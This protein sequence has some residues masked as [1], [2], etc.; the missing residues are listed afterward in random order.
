MPSD[1]NQKSVSVPALKFYSSPFVIF[2]LAIVIIFVAEFLVM[3][4][5]TQLPEVNA[6][7]TAL[8]DSFLL[9]LLII[10]AFYAFVYRP[11][12]ENISQ[13]RKAEAE[14]VQAFELDRIKGHFISI[15]AHELATPLASVMGYSE[16]LLSSVGLKKKECRDYLQVIYDKS[17][18]LDRLTNDLLDLSRIDSGHVVH[19]KKSRQSLLPVAESALHY[20]QY[21]FPDQTIETFFSPDV[22]LLQID[23]VRIGQLLENL[24]GNAIKYSPSG[25]AI[26][27]KV[28]TDLNNVTLSVSDQGIGMTS[29]ECE[30][31]FEKFY[32]ADRS[33]TA[34]GGLGLGMTIAREIVSGHGG[35]IHVESEKGRGTKVKVTFPCD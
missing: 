28:E 35:T 23:D 6:F 33:N 20:F 22:P 8:I 5:L 18:V 3:M 27:V 15:A 12:K 26:E 1:S 17:L 9:S 19:F 30:R 21:K 10:P 14:Q 4:V 13:R 29:E 31:I 11:L 25:G 2:I 16:L 24:I 7:Y 32:R 34:I